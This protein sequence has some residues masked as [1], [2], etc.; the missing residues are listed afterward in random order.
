MGLELIC[1]RCKAP[2]CAF[3][4]VVTFR[5]DEGVIQERICLH[6]TRITRESGR[7]VSERTHRALGV[8]VAQHRGYVIDAMA[9][10]ICGS[11]DTGLRQK[12]VALIH[13]DRILRG[14]A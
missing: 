12:T 4:N 2:M 9:R 10:A 5:V 11:L 7:E 14:E 3:Q 1:D 8:L 6:C 13:H